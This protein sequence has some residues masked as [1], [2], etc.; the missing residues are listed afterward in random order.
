MLPQGY[1]TN[2]RIAVIDALDINANWKVLIEGGLEAYQFRIAHK[3]TFGPHFP[4]NLLTYKQFG[5]HMRAVLPRNAISKLDG[6]TEEDWN[7]RRD[8]NMVYTVLPNTQ[9]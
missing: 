7:L 1:F 3:K 6:T 2:H 9:C 8:S 5:P 4:D